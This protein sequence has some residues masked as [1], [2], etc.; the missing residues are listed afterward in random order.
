MKKKILTTAI[1]MLIVIIAGTVSAMALTKKTTDAVS[2]A[3]QKTSTT[4]K[5]AKTQK[6]F[7]AAELAAFDGKNGSKAYIAVNGTVY[8]VTKLFKNGKH[9][10]AQAGQDLTSA[11]ENQHSASKLKDFTIV[12]VMQEGIKESKNAL[13]EQEQKRMEELLNE[14]QQLDQKEYELKQNYLSGRITLSD[15][16]SQKEAI[17]I[18]DDSIEM[19]L[20]ALENKYDTDYDDDFNDVHDSDDYDDDYHDSHHDDND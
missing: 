10:G 3:T 2:G 15:Y 11:F 1:V 7:T 5:S 18:Q 6:T 17:D 12:G 20:D 8:D 13:T 14:E 19:E 9:N 4:E 16:R